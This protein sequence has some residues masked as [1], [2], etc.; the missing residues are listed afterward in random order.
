MHPCDTLP[1]A[2]SGSASFAFVYGNMQQRKQQ[3]A[4]INNQLI[5]K[6]IKSFFHLGLGFG[7]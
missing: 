3:A 7:V 6:L 5:K 1:A 4:A 2:V